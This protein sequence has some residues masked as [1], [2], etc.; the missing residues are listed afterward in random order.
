MIAS[1][2]LDYKKWKLNN[3]DTMNDFVSAGLT[4][5]N[6]FDQL[7]SASMVGGPNER[8]ESIAPISNRFI[9]TGAN[10]YV[11]FYNAIEVNQ[12]FNKFNSFF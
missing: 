11:N 5:E 7:F 10:P 12:Y 2:N 9:T 1:L 4:S 6:R 3:H 8:F